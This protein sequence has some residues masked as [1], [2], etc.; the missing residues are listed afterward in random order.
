[1]KAVTKLHNRPFPRKLQILEGNW[2]WK[3]TK[4][5]ILRKQREKGDY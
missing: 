2:L 3:S 4:K 1:M 5:E